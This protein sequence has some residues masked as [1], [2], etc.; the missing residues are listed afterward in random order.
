MSASVLASRAMQWPTLMSRRPPSAGW[1][2]DRRRKNSRDDQHDE[3]VWR[4]EE[5]KDTRSWARVLIMGIPN[6]NSS[7]GQRNGGEVANLLF[8]HTREVREVS[9]GPCDYP[10]QALQ[11]AAV[12][13]LAIV[14][15]SLA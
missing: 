8:R 13:F 6:W 9:G 2:R 10:R 11:Q 4:D 14:A 7:T 1:R 12:R 15:A 5:S 3:C